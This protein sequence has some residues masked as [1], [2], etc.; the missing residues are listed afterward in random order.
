MT[1]SP[2]KGSGRQAARIGVESGAAM[3]Y[4]CASGEATHGR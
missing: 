4:G 3:A 2:Q 1:P